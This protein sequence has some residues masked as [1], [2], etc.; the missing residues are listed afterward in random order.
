VQ[1]AL[2]AKAHARQGIVAAGFQLLI[3]FL[4]FQAGVAVLFVRPAARSAIDPD[5]QPFP[6]LSLRGAA[7]YGVVGIITAG[8]IGR[9][10]RPS[11]R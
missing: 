9:S 7:R 3:P 11:T 4:P 2:G 1:R 5:L 8:L 6:N 10:C